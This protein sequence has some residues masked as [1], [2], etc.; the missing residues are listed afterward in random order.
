M[1]EIA[2]ALSF[3]PKIIIFDEATASLSERETELLFH[4]STS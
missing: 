4:K 2:K 1:I 3:N